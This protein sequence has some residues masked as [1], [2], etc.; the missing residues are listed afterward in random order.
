MRAIISDVHANLE[1]L[2]AVLAD[3]DRQHVEDIYCLGDIVGYGPDPL[4]CLDLVMR[5]CQVVVLGN[6]D[7]AVLTEPQL[8][9]RVAERAIRW[10]R[11]RLQEPV[12]DQRTAGTRWEYLTNRPLLH[13]A[14]G[15]L[16]VHGSPRDPISEYV[17]PEDVDDEEKM[18]GLFAQVERGCFMGHTHWPGIF[19]DKGKDGPS[20]F[21]GPDELD[22]CYRLSDHRFLCNVGSVGQPRDGD[23]RACYVLFDANTIRFRRIEYDIDATVRK[24]QEN[25]D[26]AVSLSD[27]LRVGH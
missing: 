23:C 12:P 25:D 16:F 18:D 11:R 8:F 21:L 9:R 10:T 1:A 22:H 7:E 19:V 6:H 14:D 2:Q 13:E 26:L 4:Q 17:Y 24:M 20:H 3:I 15:F 27:R 5:C